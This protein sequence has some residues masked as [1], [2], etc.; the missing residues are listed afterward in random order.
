M[1]FIDA[2]TSTFTT[3]SDSAASFT[4]KRFTGL[5]H[6]IQYVRDSTATALSTAAGLTV[7]AQRSGWNV[8]VMGTF[9][10]TIDLFLFPRFNIHSSAGSTIAGFE[11]F[12][13]KDEGLTFTLSSGGATKGGLFRTFIS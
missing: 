8:L 5:L 11:Q 4:T 2:D 12:P 13:L 10:S 3:G 9:N 6:S 1:S 7:A